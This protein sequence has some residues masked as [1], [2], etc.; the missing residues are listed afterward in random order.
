M[1]INKGVLI[2]DDHDMAR[3]VSIIPLED[4]RILVEFCSGEKRI[5]DMTPYIDE[6]YFEGLRDK[7]IFN[8]VECAT[9]DAPR[10]QNEELNLDAIFGLCTIYEDGINPEE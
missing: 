3:A 5:F 9:W 4:Y 10:W 6:P 1:Y 7:E 8:S 2:T